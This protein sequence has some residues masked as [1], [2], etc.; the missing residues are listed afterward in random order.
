MLPKY[1]NCSCIAINDPI[2]SAVIIIARG[3]PKGGKEHWQVAALPSPPNYEGSDL[4]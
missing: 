2:F 4:V 3:A 1:P